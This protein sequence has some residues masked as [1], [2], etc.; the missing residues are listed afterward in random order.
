[1]SDIDRKKLSNAINHFNDS[2]RIVE[3][4]RI[5]TTG[6]ERGGWDRTVRT[7]EIL[8]DELEERYEATNKGENK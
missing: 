3:G 1:M 2:I 6:E 5:N 4:L 7:L 8:V